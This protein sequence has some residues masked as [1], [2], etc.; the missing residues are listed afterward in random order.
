VAGGVT[1]TAERFSEG[2]VLTDFD[3]ILANECVLAADAGAALLI[4]FILLASRPTR[5]D[6]SCGKD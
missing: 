3:A 1:E 6:Q 2:F 5:G 4:T